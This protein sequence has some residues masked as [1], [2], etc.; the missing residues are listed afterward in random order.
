MH[1][2]YVF[3]LEGTLGIFASR[4]HVNDMIAL[5]P[6][7]EEALGLISEAGLPV[8]VATRAPKYYSEEVR[9]NLKDRCGIAIDR[10]YTRDDVRLVSSNS[11]LELGCYKNYRQVYRDF[12]I[13]NPD[14]VAVFGDFL[15]FSGMHYRKQDYIS[16][17]FRSSP[18]VLSV[19]F[20]LND[21]PV[22]VDGKVPLY[23]V[24]P[25]PWTTYENG[26]L[27]SLRLDYVVQ[28]LREGPESW[29]G[30][31]QLVESSRAS[32]KFQGSSVSDSR[33]K[34]LSDEFARPFTQPYLVMKGEDGDWEELRRVM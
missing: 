15:R 10:L 24:V 7:T 31:D 22:P 26:A 32:E 19:S 30:A 23:V 34:D 21:H 5:R 28:K 11:D 17:D 14:D 6:G 25:Q 1:R 18:E 29:N 33:G 12:G 3:D 20:S 4:C 27:H 2:L 8:V 13:E 16:F 9:K